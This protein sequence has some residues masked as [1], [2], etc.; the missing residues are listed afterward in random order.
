MLYDCKSLSVS[1]GKVFIKMSYV[2]VDEVLQGVAASKPGVIEH[3]LQGLRRK[4]LYT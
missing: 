2:L 3:I 1:T 4:V